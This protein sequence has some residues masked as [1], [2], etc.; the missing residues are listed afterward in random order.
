VNQIFVDSGGWFA[1]LVAEDA[2]H[3]TARRLFFEARQQRRGLVTTNAV[4]FETYALLVSR[5]REGRA[6]ALD[7]LGDIE[8]GLCHVVRVTKQDERRAVDLLRRHADKTYSLCDALSFVVMERL[9]VRQAIAFD[10]H[11]R[12]YGVNVLE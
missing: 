4:V 7:L 3:A 12:Q 9:G 5:A 10:R 6:L 11:F 1:H 2:D 8:A